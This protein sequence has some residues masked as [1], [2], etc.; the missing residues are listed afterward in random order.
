M[1]KSMT[2]K[3]LEELESRA[4]VAITEACREI[5]ELRDDQKDWQKGVAL[6]ASA[7]NLDT[8]CCVDINHA[9]L[10][11]MATI[12]GHEAAIREVLADC[13]DPGGCASCE[14]LRARLKKP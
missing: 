10:E 4:P 8:L 3:R 12:E 5:R 6:I 9:A 13:T 11:A 7:L 1:S 2:N 14:I